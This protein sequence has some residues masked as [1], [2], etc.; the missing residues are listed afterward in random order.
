VAPEL[1][2]EGVWKYE[3]L[4]Q[5]CMELNGL[6]VALQGECQPDTWYGIKNVRSIHLM[7]HGASLD[8]TFL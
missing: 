1:Q 8:Q 4:R 3:H 2:D 7:A 6:A 5:F